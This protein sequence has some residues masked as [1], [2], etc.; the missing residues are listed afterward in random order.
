MSNATE[1]PEDR[2]D[3]IAQSDGSG[4]HY[5]SWWTAKTCTKCGRQTAAKVS[6]DAPMCP[7]CV[8][9]DEVVYATPRRVATQ[10][11]A[12]SPAHYQAGKVECIDALDSA[13]VNKTGIEAVCTA[14]VIKYLWRYELKNGIEDVRKAR[15]Y[16]ERLIQELEP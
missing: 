12:I 15:W 6:N 4:S 5:E 9:C 8:T 7:D 11:D 1:W 16:L 14:N 2:I 13:T 10:H 3:R